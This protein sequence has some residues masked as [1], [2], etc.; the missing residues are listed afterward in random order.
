[1]EHE[2]IDVLNLE[3]E[4]WNRTDRVQAFNTTLNTLSYFKSVAQANNLQ[5]E[6]YIGWINEQE[7]LA[8]SSAVDRILVHYYRHNDTDII[9]YGL[10]RLHFLA[11]GNNKVKI[12]PIFSN[13][14]PGNSADPSGYFMGP[15]LENHK[16]DQ[17]FTSWF[18]QYQNLQGDW[19]QNLEVMGASWFLYNHFS[20]IKAINDSAPSQSQKN[21]NCINDA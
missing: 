16:I 14:G 13:E 12:A 8:L 15:W 18:K 17:A 9:D 6:I 19:K 1:M 4:F 7:G 5:T 3:Y 11:A 10:E 20:D 21:K 2:R